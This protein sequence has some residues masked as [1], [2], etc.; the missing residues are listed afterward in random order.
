MWGA[1]PRSRGPQIVPVPVP[2]AAN[3]GARCADA[4]TAA[5]AV[6]GERL[7]L[8]L[9]LPAA[10][11]VPAVAVQAV[12]QFLVLLLALVGAVVAAVAGAGAVGVCRSAV[13]KARPRALGPQVVDVG[14]AVD[15]AGA[16][17]REVPQ[18]D[19]TAVLCAFGVLLAHGTVPVARRYLEPTHAHN[20]HNTQHTQH[21]HIAYRHTDIVRAELGTVT[22]RLTIRLRTPTATVYV[23]STTA[24][25]PRRG[26]G[27][28]CATPSHK[29]RTTVASPSTAY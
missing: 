1:T 7:P 6:L 13:C 16:R 27:T 12:A 24:P 8:L 23:T 21:T 4:A 19:G 5:A 29:C 14:H 17:R 10:G 18:R 9:A 22:H 3:A 11:V 28:P 15:A 25:L 20:T 26:S 2:I